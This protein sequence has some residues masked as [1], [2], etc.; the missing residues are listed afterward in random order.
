[1][2]LLSKVQVSSRAEFS[3]NV[4]YFPSLSCC[5]LNPTLILLTVTLRKLSLGFR[6]LHMFFLDTE[7][8]QED[9]CKEIQWGVPWGLITMQMWGMANGFTRLFLSFQIFLGVSLN[10]WNAHIKNTLSKGYFS[11]FLIVVG[12]YTSLEQRFIENLTF[13]PQGAVISIKTMESV[14]IGNK[15]IIVIYFG[16]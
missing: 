16:Y 4:Q 3:R 11:L 13:L 1:M 6:H 12:E 9:S 5:P 14:T 8:S 2:T 7:Y 15:I 10:C